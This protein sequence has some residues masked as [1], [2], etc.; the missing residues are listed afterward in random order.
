MSWTSAVKSW[1]SLQK[2]P[3]H[4]LVEHMKGSSQ[5]VSGSGSDSRSLSLIYVTNATVKNV[6]IEHK[7][8]QKKWED[9]NRK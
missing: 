1:P 6:D 9:K 2:A 8:T 5:S 4:G 3:Y 7:L